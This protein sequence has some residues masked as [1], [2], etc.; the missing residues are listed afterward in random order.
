MQVTQ[1]GGAVPF[2]SVNGEDLYYTK[3]QGLWKKP[4]RGG[5]EIRVGTPLFRNNFALTKRGIYFLQASPS[6]ETPL[7]FQFLDFATHAVQTI[8]VI[9]GPV[10]DEISVSPDQR[11]LLFNKNDREGSEL[12]LIENFH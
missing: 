2:E 7:H 10:C 12:M 9:P 3:D 6:S 1:H 8:A 11:W 5:D 4:V